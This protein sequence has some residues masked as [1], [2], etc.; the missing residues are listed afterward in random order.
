MRRYDFDN[1]GL[2]DSN[3]MEKAKIGYES[4]YEKPGDYEQISYA[5]ENNC[6]VEP[7]E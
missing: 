3:E 1:N 7:A 2:I 5:Y 6:P 4:N